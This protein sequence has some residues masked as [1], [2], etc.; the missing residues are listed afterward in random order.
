[1]KLAFMTFSCP[2]LTL[3]QVL[4][5]A[6]KY[7][8]EGVEFR[9]V[10]KHKHGIEPY[11]SQKEILEA[12]AVIDASPVE[13]VAIATSCKFAD[14]GTVG[15]NM[16]SAEAAIDLAAALEIP[17]IRTFG[18]AYP[19]DITKE[20]A[21]ACLVDSYGK[22]GEYAQKNKVT[23]CFE[24]H[25]SWCNPHDVASIIKQ[26]NNEYVAINWD[27]MH[28]ITHG[29]NMVEAFEAVKPYIKH[30]HVHDGI[31]D[32]TG[33]RLLA[34]IGTG[35]VDHKIALD[36]LKSID[37]K[38]AISGEWISWEPYEIHLPRELKTLRQY[39]GK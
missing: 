26:V 33:K 28:P 16:K 4:A 32:E 34:P 22:L 13:A 37:Y 8:Y 3:E 21:I 39:L 25:D 12:K 10:S 14:P 19:A 9:T 7:G 6:E 29:H 30:V 15:E 38:G 5:L 11:I 36:C 27:I 2:E 1:M 35:Y 23:V 20:Q 24:T 18:G 31:Q 17:V